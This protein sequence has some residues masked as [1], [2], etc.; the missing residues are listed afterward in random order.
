MTAPQPAHAPP[1]IPAQ[2]SPDMMLATGEAPRGA[3]PQNALGAIASVET[4]V[5][6][7]RPSRLGDVIVTAYAPIGAGTPA[8]QQMQS[9]IESET[10]GSIAMAPRGGTALTNSV[11]SP[12]GADALSNYAAARADRRNAPQLLASIPVLASFATRDTQLVAP[13]YDSNLVRP[14][15]MTSGTFAL[16]VEPAATDL[17]PAT[18]LGPMVMH[19]DTHGRPAATLEPQPACADQPRRCCSPRVRPTALPNPAAIAAGF[20]RQIADLIALAAAD[21]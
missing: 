17:D 10:T 4:P 20:P 5:P 7:P 8:E 13:G 15:A 1:P 6:S 2:K 11:G 21:I 9:I 18:E 3:Q 14:A 19:L 12:V 16:F